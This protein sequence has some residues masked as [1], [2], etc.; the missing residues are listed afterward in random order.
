M[1]REWLKRGITVL[2]LAGIIAGTASL[3][4]MTR[5]KPAKA[6]IA[7]AIV[8]DIQR[9]I[10]FFKDEGFKITIDEV[11]QIVIKEV[12]KKMIE[13]II[14]GQQGGIA[15]G[16][17]AFVSDYYK[18]LY[19][20]N[21]KDT[22]TYIDEQFD[23]LFPSYI[24]PA[25]KQQIKSSFDDQASI[26]PSSCVDPSS[27]DFINDPDATTKLVHAAQLGCNQL[28]AQVLLYGQALAYNDRLQNQSAQELQANSGLV[29]K[30]DDEQGKKRNILKQSGVVYSG[31]IQGAL[32][33]VYGVQINNQ[34]AISSVIGSFVDQLLDELLNT[35][36]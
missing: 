11:R 28:S 3:Y 23:K 16:G 29:N 18:Y 14:G 31:V 33:A 4:D 26:V 9:W 34:S 32:A 7:A 15:G 13:K 12:T 2:L 35:Q 36:Y 8:V 21:D 22:R 10:Q 20:D 5:P 30:S 19:T 1:K 25:I 24:D 27:I 6:Q 17:S